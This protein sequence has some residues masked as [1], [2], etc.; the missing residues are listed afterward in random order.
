[1]R[2]WVVQ[3]L[4]CA[5]A[6]IVNTL[7]CSSLLSY[8]YNVS[9]ICMLANRFGSILQQYE[10]RPVW[11]RMLEPANNPVSNPLHPNVTVNVLQVIIFF[12]M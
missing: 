5:P 4:E 3:V 10:R 2:L 6:Y 11:D 7:L 8:W 9:Y 12:L 1:M